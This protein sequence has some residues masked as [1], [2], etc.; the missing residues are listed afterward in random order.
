[1]T[2]STVVLQSSSVSQQP[3]TQR[4]RMHSWYSFTQYTW[5]PHTQFK[6]TH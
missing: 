3:N 4:G 6:C 1:M 5:L 2:T